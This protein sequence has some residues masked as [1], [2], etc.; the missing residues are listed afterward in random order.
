MSVEPSPKNCAIP[1]IIREMN[2]AQREFYDTSSKN[3]IF[4]KTQKMECAR[5]VVDRFNFE[6]I[7]KCTCYRLPENPIAVFFDYTVFKMFANERNYTA[8]VQYIMALLDSVIQTYGKF[9]F[10][11]NIQSFTVSAAERYRPIIDIFSNTCLASNTLYSEV[12]TTFYT[13]HTPS[14]VETVRKML[15]PIVPPLIKTKLV[16]V[17]KKDSDERLRALLGDLYY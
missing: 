6:D 7:M 15:G 11:T 10:H 16:F 9:E 17:N 3:S 14:I 4:K 2:I 12:L 13:Y 8:I 1:N 5:L